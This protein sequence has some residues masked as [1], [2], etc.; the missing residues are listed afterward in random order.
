[1]LSG[2]CYGAYVLG[3]KP[4]N[5]IALSFLRNGARA[6]VGCTGIHYSDKGDPPELKYGGRFHELFWIMVVAGADPLDA[7]YTAKTQYASG[8]VTAAQKKLMH[9]FVYYGRP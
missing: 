8:A 9:E 4:S 7:F 6:F 1:V 3:K 5:S 2:C